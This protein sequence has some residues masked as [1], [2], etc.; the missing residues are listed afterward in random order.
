MPM[1]NYATDP[2]VEA[3]TLVDLL[4]YRASY[5]PNRLAYTFL[6]N[7]ETEQ[8]SLTYADLDRRARAI[9]AQLQNLAAPGARA[10]LLYQP[11]LDYIAAFLG[12]LYAGIIAIPAYPPRSHRPSPRLGA[13]MTDAQAS[14]GLTTASIMSN[15]ECQFDQNPALAALHWLT[16]DTIADDL[17]EAWQDTMIGSD[18]L[19]YLQ[20]TS[21]S[22]AAPKGVMVG[23][24]N[25]IH[26]LASLDDGWEHNQDSLMVSWLPMFHDLGLV[27]GVLQALYNGFPCVLM[28]PM[29]F[30]QKPARWLQAISRY[31]ATHSAAPNFAYELCARKVTP[32][33][34]ADLD[35]SSWCVALNGAEPVRKDTL[36]RFT[37]IFAPYGFRPFTFCPGYGLAEATLKVS[38]TPK[39]HLPVCCMV[40]TDVLQQHRVVEIPEGQ[41]QAR[42]LVASGR[43]AL[44]TQ[45]RIV[46][47]ELLTRCAPDQVGE[48][49]VAGS[50][51]AQG[52]WRRPVETEQTFCA[53]LADTGEGPFLRTGD[54]G[55]VKDGELFVTGRLKDLIIIGGRNHYPQDIELTVEQSHPALRA[56]CSAAC[57][58]EIDHQERLIIAAEVDRHY[59]PDRSQGE[60]TSDAGAESDLAPDVDILHKIIRRAVSEQHDLQVYAVSLL[61]AGSIPKTTSGKIQRHACRAG[62]LNKTLNV[63]EPQ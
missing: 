48:I 4:R 10:L 43:P 12:C 23:H 33:Q 41:V 59:R 61:K 24:G 58:V 18:A 52:Y 21:G 54:L 50:G 57:S 1:M 13:I 19:A 3:T 51:V 63:W 46:H 20:Y 29:A 28:A 31:R 22:I 60:R 6:H 37:E 32:E 11:G 17:T 7:G 14:I 47:P 34:R 55:F 26:N 9:G 38:S 45:I 44:D 39:T 16:S 53:Y 35:L 30:L 5:Q 8:A 15:L 25:L 2:T 27:Y 49:W 62:F 36:E 56:G 42:A 40:D